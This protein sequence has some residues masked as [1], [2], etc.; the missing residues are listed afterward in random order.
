VAQTIQ[1][2]DG[3][4]ALLPDNTSRIISALAA[5]DLLVSAWGAVLDAPPTMQDDSANTAGNG[6]FDFGS[7][8]TDKKHK[9]FYW[10]FDGTPNAAV[11]WE[12]V[13]VQNAPAATVV[14]AVAPLHS[15]FDGSHT[16]TLTTDAPMPPASLLTGLVAYWTLNET[17]GTRADQTA[18]YPLLDTGT[19]PTLAV[20]AVI[21]E[22]ANL[23]ASLVNILQAA[24]TIPV[25]VGQGFTVAGWLKLNGS[26]GNTFFQDGDVNY[27]GNG[28]FHLNDQGAA[29]Y[30]F[31][32]AQAPDNS[33]STCGIGGLAGSFVFVR[34]W[35]DPADQKVKIKVNETGLQ[36]GAALTA[37][38]SISSAGLHVSL[39]HSGFLGTFVGNQIGVWNRV[40]TDDEGVFLY[41]SGN[42]RT[43]P[44]DSA[45][46]NVPAN[47]VDAG[48]VTGAPGPLIPRL[49]DDRD[50][51]NPL[52]RGVAFVGNADW[53]Y[54]SN[55]PILAGTTVGPN[56]LTA[57]DVILLVQQASKSTNGP[58]VIAVGTWSRPAWFPDGVTFA[59]P[60]TIWASAWLTSTSPFNTVWT[61]QVLGGTAHDSFL[62][63]T[64]DLTCLWHRTNTPV[65][66]PAFMSTTDGNILDDTPFAIAFDLQPANYV[67]AGPATGSPA[68]PDFRPLV[69]ADLP[70]FYSSWAGLGFVPAAD[71][72]AGYPYS[73][74]AG[75]PGPVCGGIKIPVLTTSSTWTPFFTATGAFGLTGQVAVRC[76]PASTTQ[77]GLR[78]DWVAWDGTTG[79][80]QL[81]VP[82]VVPFVNA[83]RID[84]LYLPGGNDGG[85]VVSITCSYSA[86]VPPNTALGF[87]TAVVWEC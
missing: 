34:A 4:L 53:V 9:R 13:F 11:W 45:T 52:V 78:I 12:L 20:P 24:A 23:N 31:A 86:L 87:A 58:W 54:F 25:G 37:P 44:F 10:C 75:S 8:W 39:T 28:G 29:G 21:G 16:Y 30:V 61:V 32:E 26:A 1:T 71:L 59:S 65:T 18:T 62:V 35:Y 14:D 63:G 73:A 76:D 15:S 42:G 70:A 47:Y 3:Q 17:I 79:F 68:A 36:V 33:F 69:A 51:P 22:G 85:P 2:R 6:H 66:A 77:L 50:M 46:P 56:L 82:G 48:P 60:R 57:G 43:Y 64:D 5:R 27:T 38:L 41:N 7:R 74:L 84:E 40:L 67:L 55:V 81:F 72:G 49:L 83:M 19:N 80:T